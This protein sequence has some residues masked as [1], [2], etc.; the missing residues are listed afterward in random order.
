MKLK[1]FF[2]MTGNRITEGSGYYWDCYG[3][4]VYTLTYWDGDSNG[5]TAECIY[6]LTTSD[7]REITAMDFSKEIAY[8]WIDSAYRESHK[9][10]VQQ[11]GVDDN[12][13]DDVGYTELEVEEDIREKAIAILNHEEFD[14]RVQV[15]LTMDDKDLY[16]LMTLAHEHDLTLNKF[17]EMVLRDAIDTTKENNKMFGMQQCI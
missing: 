7:V 11:R 14:T 12:A 17:V 6:D 1:D 2:E 13:Q 4:S 10:E 3:D 15:P 5:V 16:Q 8:R 9:N